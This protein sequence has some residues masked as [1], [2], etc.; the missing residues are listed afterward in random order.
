MNFFLQLMTFT[1]WTTALL[2]GV[3]GFLLPYWRPGGGIEA[4]SKVPSDQAIHVHLFKDTLVRTDNVPSSVEPFEPIPKV[5]L[6]EESLPVQPATLTDVV[7]QVMDASSANFTRI[8]SAKVRPLTYAYTYEKRQ[9]TQPAPR[10]PFRA[11]REGQEGMVTVVFTVNENGRVT[12]A[13]LKQGC[14]WPLLNE[15]A[16]KAI[17]NHWRFSKGADRR[18]E[19]DINFE[20]KESL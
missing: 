19:I 16:L 15:S 12:T 1:G 10:Y 2:I 11:V 9:G 20:L 18:F 13:R 4:R 6:L 5:P 3:L 8:E 17:R 14:P 7:T